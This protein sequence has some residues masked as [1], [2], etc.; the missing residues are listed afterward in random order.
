M[1]VFKL[2]LLLYLKDLNVRSLVA[3]TF[4]Q[5]YLSGKVFFFPVEFLQPQFYNKLA[6]I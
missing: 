4:K 5:K 6:K 2:Q 3:A 1:F